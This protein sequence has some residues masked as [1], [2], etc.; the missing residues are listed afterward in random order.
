MAKARQVS[1]N[2]SR[3]STRDEADLIAACRNGRKEAFGELVRRYQDRV[4][5]LTFRLTG[6]H[7]DASDATQET[8]LKAYRGLDLFRAE[9]AFYTWLYRIVVNT[10]RSRRRFRAMRPVEQSLDANPGRHRDAENGARQ[11]LH[12]ELPANGPDPVEEA[13]RAEN[14]Q[15]VEQALARLDRDSRTLIVL[16]DIEG[17]NYAEIADLLDCPRGTVKSRL[18]RARLAL[19][20]VLAPAF[21]GT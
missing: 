4:F 13:S 9:C 15:L 1:S 18:H 21:A 7:D 10:V 5:N 8:F 6:H 3:E 19:K 2:E 17:R 12:S 16:R 20:D 14:K 11:S